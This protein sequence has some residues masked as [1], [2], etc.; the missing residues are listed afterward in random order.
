M[1]ARVTSSSSG[2]RHA[3]CQDGFLSLLS[4]MNSR[5]KC[6]PEVHHLVEEAENFFWWTGRDGWSLASILQVGCGMTRRMG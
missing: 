5:N 4:A 2:Q 3:Q 1:R 6:G